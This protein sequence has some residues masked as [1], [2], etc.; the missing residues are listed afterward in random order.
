MRLIQRLF[1][2][3][4]PYINKA[5][6][7]YMHVESIGIGM[8]NALSPFLG[9]LLTR[10]E[11]TAFQISL[12]TSM[13]ALAGLFLV[14]PLGQV[15]QSQ[16]NIIRWYSISRIIYV[17]AFTL[18]G[19]C[20]LVLPPSLRVPLILLV[21]LLVTLPQIILNITFQITMNGIAGPGGRYELMSRRWIIMGA[22][23]ALLS[24]WVGQIL[25]RT[26]FPTN[27]GAVFIF[28]SI[29]GGFLAYNFSRLFKIDYHEKPKTDH[30]SSIR[31]VIQDTITHLKNNR[32]FSSFIFK[33]FMIN[34]GALLI[35]PLFSIYFVR[36][37]HASD[38]WIAIF[39]TTSTATTVVGYFFWMQSSRKGT[40]RILL[41]TT[42]GTSLYPLLTAI[43]HQEWLIAIYAGINGLFAAGLN[44]VFF[45]ELLKTIPSDLI[46]MYVAISQG[47]TYFTS[48][49]API[50][51]S[52]ISDY[53]GVGPTL[54][55]GGSIQFFGFLLF[56][57]E[58]RKTKS[59][60]PKTAPESDHI[61][62]H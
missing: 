43:T 45:D 51:G 16:K 39:N 9:V 14:I 4:S 30:V 13:P 25:D 53:I 8:A 62:I 37:I 61:C 60:H 18:T 38:S 36:E 5:N 28:L 47:F 57:F 17:S 3:H 2:P 44:L 6:F 32:T 59:I 55:I 19:I 48:I 27:Y 40:G 12:L 11:A 58:K 21:W 20:V 34:F 50:T 10:L 31:I 29:I 24:F 15:L 23:T 33:R 35:S 49:I 7:I 41:W 22:A 46:A 54:L 1:T 42:F 26:Q 52:F 56:L